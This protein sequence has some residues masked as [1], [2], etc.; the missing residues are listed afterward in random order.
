MVVLGNPPYATFGRINHNPWILGLFN[1]YKK[2]VNEKKLNLDDN[3]IK[4]IRFA[5]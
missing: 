3:F 5:Q 1:D 2:D 4:F